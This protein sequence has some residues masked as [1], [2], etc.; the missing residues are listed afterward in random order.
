MINT[1]LLKKYIE[2]KANLDKTT[3]SL[4][5]K[6]SA[7][8]E[9]ITDLVAEKKSLAEEVETLLT[10][11]KE[12][13]LAEYGETGSKTLTGG[14]KVQTKSTLSYDKDV[15][16]KWATEKGMFLSLDEKAFKKSAP[17]LNLDFVTEEKNDIVTVPKVVKLN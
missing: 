1:E 14:F 12:E 15:A 11:I 4:A 6:K 7:Y 17:S 2:V 13:A 5:D 8:E 9:S 16:L 3:A 10:S